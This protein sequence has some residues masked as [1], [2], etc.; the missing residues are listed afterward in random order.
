VVATTVLVISRG[1]EQFSAIIHKEKCKAL[2]ATIYQ[3]SLPIP[4]EADLSCRQ[5]NEILFEEVTYIEV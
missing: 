2:R 3:E 4:I 1:L 5:G